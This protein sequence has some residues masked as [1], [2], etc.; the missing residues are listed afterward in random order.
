MATGIGFTEGIA[1][2]IFGSMQQTLHKANR[3]H[4][5]ILL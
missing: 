4:R 1:Q 5:Q 2:L 3:N